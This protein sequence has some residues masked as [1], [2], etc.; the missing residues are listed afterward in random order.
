MRLFGAASGGAVELFV[1]KAFRL[2]QCSLRLRQARC[3][4]G[5]GSGILRS[6]N[7][8]SRIAHFLHRRARTS[9]QQQHSH[10]R[11]TRNFRT[12]ARITMHCLALP[13][14]PFE[15]FG[16]LTTVSDSVK[17]ATITICLSI[18]CSQRYD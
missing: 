5:G 3:C 10:C 9:A 15:F 14:L 11:C 6:A 12:T 2:V 1:E 16:N 7:C 17:P 13:S 4:L 18:L 8:L